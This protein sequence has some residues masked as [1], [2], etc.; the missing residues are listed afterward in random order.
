[1]L[2][3]DAQPASWWLAGRPL[4]SSSRPQLSTSTPLQYYA[5]PGE[6]LPFAP[7]SV[8]RQ[9][10]GQQQPW[11]PPPVSAALPL[12]LAARADPFGRRA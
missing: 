3:T 7:S 6:R 9:A 1:M 4:S 12:A 10:P 2:R 8:A 11:L 5:A